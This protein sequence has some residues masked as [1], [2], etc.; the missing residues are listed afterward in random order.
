MPYFSQFLTS[1]STCK[2]DTGS[3]IPAARSVVGTLWSATARI[4]LTRQGA[5]LASSK[6]SNAWGLVTSCTKCL[7]IYNKQ[8]PSLASSMTCE[9]NN[10]SY[11]VFA[12]SLYLCKQITPNH[13]LQTIFFVLV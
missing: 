2:R 4:E 6:P 3:A 1:V 13:I 12:I 5:R 9:S 8:V 7:S 11:K 10:L